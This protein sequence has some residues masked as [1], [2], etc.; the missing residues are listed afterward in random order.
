MDSGMR[1]KWVHASWFFYWWVCIRYWSTPQLLPARY[2]CG[3]EADRG[4]IYKNR[5]FTM[6]ISA[7]KE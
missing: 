6:D 3:I 7:A 5:K 1:D 4:Y 2:F